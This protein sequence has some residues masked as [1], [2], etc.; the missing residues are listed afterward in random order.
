MARTTRT[1]N[2][3]PYGDLDP[4]RFEDLVRQLA[5]EFRDWIQSKRPGEAAR[6]RASTFEQV[7]PLP[8]EDQRQDE[9]RD[10]EQERPN[11]LTAESWPV[12][13]FISR[14]RLSA[15]RQIPVR[16]R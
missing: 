13:H 3:L 16:P 8:A 6:T 7:G 15:E 4:H 10:E 12:E 11:I 9:G 2:P 1:L 14:S 5:Y